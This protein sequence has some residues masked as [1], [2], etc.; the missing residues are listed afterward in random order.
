MQNITVKRLIKLFI[1]FLIIIIV[2]ITVFES[3]ENNNIESVESKA[4]QNFPSTSLKEVFLNLE[5]KKSYDEEIISNV[6]RFIDNRYDASDFKTIS[7]LRF[8]YSPHY[9]LTEKNKKEIELTLL[10]FKYWMSDGSNDSMCY[11]S[12][13]HQILFSVSEY[14]A[15][16]MFSDKIFTQTGFTGKQ[17]KQRA[18]KRILIWLE[19]RWNYGFSEWYSNQY[20][21]EDIAA[22]ANLI[23][24]C[25]D[26]EIVEKSKIIMDLIIYDI[27]SQSFYG[28][29]TSTTTRAYEKNRK[30]GEGNALRAVIDSIWDYNLNFDNRLGLEMNF[31]A[32]K[33]YTIPKVLYLIGKDRNTVEIKSSSGIKLSEINDLGFNKVD[34]ASIMMQWGMEAF[35]N[36][37]VVSNTLDIIETYD[38]YSNEF[39]NDFTKLNYT[40]LKKSGLIAPIIFFINP[41]TNGIAMQQGDNYTFKTKDYMVATAM[42][43]YPGNFGDQ[44]HIQSITLSDDVC[45]YNTHPAVKEEEKGLNGN[46]PTYW[47][48]YGYLPD[49]VQYKNVAM[50]IYK[51]PKRS[52]IL[53]APILDY[54][55]TWFPTEK[56]DA[57]QIDNNMAFA[58]KNS[59]Y[60]AIISNNDLNLYEK[61]R[62]I[63]EGKDTFWIYELSSCEDFESFDSFK[64]Y[65]KSNKVI[66]NDGNLEYING[67]LDLN[68]IYDKAFF[69]NDEIQRFDYDRFDS[70]Y[71]KAKRGDSEIVFNYKDE[72]LV[73]N[74]EKQKRE[75]QSENVK[76]KYTPS[77]VN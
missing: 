3:I 70:P 2:G 6:C 40:L 26:E 37:E 60:L 45:I 9:A 13:N 18:K 25:D 54:T 64:E 15:G 29:F 38:M 75:F 50:S 21:V 56:F 47:V 66:Y 51:L 1:V 30:S 27:A 24:F 52:G 36:S 61:N 72:K 58:K 67:S 31:L 48:G 4:P 7:L 19:Q 71:V 32:M 11:W 10:N 23:D 55:Y 73:L 39:L 42:N 63:Q 46:S 53:K 41:Q 28:N 69:I 8:I 76:I 16:Q 44:H 49:A 20:Y 14:L 65:I 59:S 74:F 77:N 22:L 62:L 12:E 5:Q 34:D 35:T 43:Y 68:L 33:N 17:H 57:W